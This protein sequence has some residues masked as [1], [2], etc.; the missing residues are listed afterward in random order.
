MKKKEKNRLN[1]R[2]PNKE[3]YKSKDLHIL[4]FLTKNQQNVYFLMK[5]YHSIQ[6][7]FL[8]K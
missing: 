3:A 4:I 1:R 8:K 5:K 2:N 6:K 7:I